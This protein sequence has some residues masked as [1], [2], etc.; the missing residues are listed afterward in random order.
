MYGGISV[1]GPRSNK[2][3]GPGR[4]NKV[5]NVYEIVGHLEKE[6]V[7]PH[8]KVFEPKCSRGMRI[9]LDSQLCLFA[10]I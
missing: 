10:S 3:N 1:F 5:L 2:P 6:K 7:R 9:I 4:S 8:A